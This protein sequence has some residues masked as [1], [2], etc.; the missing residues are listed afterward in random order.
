M[1]NKKITDNYAFHIYEG[2]FK[3]Y[4]RDNCLL[5]AESIEELEKGTI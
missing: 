4:I 2:A 5:S 3:D 1:L